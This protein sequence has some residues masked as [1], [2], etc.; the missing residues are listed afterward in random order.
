M[1]TRL[2]RTLGLAAAAFCILPQAHAVENTRLTRPAAFVVELF[3]KGILYSI[4]FDH[5][6]SEALAIGLGFGQVP[7][8]SPEG[9]QTG[10][11]A[12]LVPFYLHY[13]FLHEKGSPFVL[14]SA[15]INASSGTA[16]GMNSTLGGVEFG[17]PILVPTVGAGYETRTQ[18]G[19]L[20]RLTGYGIASRKVNPWFGMSF[21]YA[22]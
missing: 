8:E 9:E 4:S 19:F 7:L 2:A 3:G 10:E 17:S 14:L 21:G 22:F 15:T 11:S 5:T 18:R 20:F 1:G 13:Y 6:Y 12:K 16:S